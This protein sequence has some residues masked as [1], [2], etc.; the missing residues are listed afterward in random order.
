MKLLP[1]SNGVH[2]VNMKKELKPKDLAKNI[3]LGIIIILVI[4]FIYQRVSNFIAK[5][6]LKQR[7]DYARVEDKRL[8]YK[9]DG[10]GKYT[11]V[12]DGN[13]GANLNQWS[14]ITDK[15]VS[16]YDDSVVFTYNRRGY[17]FSDSG[18][19]RTP[20]EQAEDLRTLLR[21]SAAPAPYILVGEEYGSLVLTEFAKAYPDL[22][23]GV[24][25]VNPLI[26]DVINTDKFKRSLFFDRIRTSV[27]SFGAEVGLTT[28][29]DKLNLSRNTDEFENMLEERELEEFKV[30][31]TK[32]SYNKAVNN[33][34]KN[35]TSGNNTSQEAGVF[36]GKPYYLIAKP[37]QEV[38]ANLGDEDLTKVYNVNYDNNIIAMYEPDTVITGIRQVIKQANEIERLQ[39]K[40]KAS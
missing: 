13:I 8:D 20:K 15:L 27:E 18:A 31:R 17:G 2:K 33:E 29:L 39:K 10:E 38:L 37:G 25:L 3:I 14:E 6:T 34:Y 30:H 1:H 16:E 22:V 19:L 35:I 11:I 4:G 5:E 7:V 40:N 23:A 28:L 9:M 21:K 36:S 26:E 32:S 24:V 12:F